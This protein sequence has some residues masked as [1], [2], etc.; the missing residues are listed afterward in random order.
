[1]TREGEGVSACLP[2]AVLA[3]ENSIHWGGPR[4]A[5]AEGGELATGV[6]S[7]A[8]EEE[9]AEGNVLPA[10]PLLPTDATGMPGR[11]YPAL[12]IRESVACAH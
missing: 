5:T 3:W 8:V 11:F 12:L 7:C 9:D 4:P 6:H 10:Q 1:M 2:V